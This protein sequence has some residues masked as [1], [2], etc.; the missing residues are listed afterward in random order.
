MTDV[1]PVAVDAPKW[2]RAPL[3]AGRASLRNREN[4]RGASAERSSLNSRLLISS[5]GAH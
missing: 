2:L 4:L 1:Q 3:E 5:P